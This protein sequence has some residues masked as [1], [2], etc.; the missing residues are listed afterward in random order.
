MSEAAILKL[1]WVKQGFSLWVSLLTCSELISS[2][3]KDKA[4]FDVDNVLWS[5]IGFVL[6]VWTSPL[7]DF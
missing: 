1:N 7:H 2:T 5:L 6:A 3:P 4:L